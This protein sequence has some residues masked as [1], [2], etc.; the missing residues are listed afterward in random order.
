MKVID[1]ENSAGYFKIQYFEDNEIVSGSINIDN[2]SV[3]NDAV[4]TKLIVNNSAGDIITIEDKDNFQFKIIEKSINLVYKEISEY[5][6]FESFNIYNERFPGIETKYVNVSEYNHFSSDDI[7][8][9]FYFKNAECTEKGTPSYMLK[10]LYEKSPRTSDETSPEGYFN[11][12]DI[13]CRSFKTNFL[14][15]NDMNIMDYC[16]CCIPKQNKIGINN[17]KLIIEE[18]TKTT[19]IIANAGPEYVFLFF[20]IF[21]YYIIT[22]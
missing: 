4:V 16:F 5:D 7:V 1:Y 15:K 22:F 10:N 12:F 8:F 3:S 20:I 2:T 18:I 9:Q 17:S 21:I 19:I 11:E 14:A 6:F 13:L